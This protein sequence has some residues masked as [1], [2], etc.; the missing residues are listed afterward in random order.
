LMS[1]FEGVTAST[2]AFSVPFVLTYQ[3]RNHRVSFHLLSQQQANEVLRH[4][5]PKSRLKGCGIWAG[6]SFLLMGFHRLAPEPRQRRCPSSPI[7]VPCRHDA[8]EGFRQ[9]AFAGP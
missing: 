4:D 9:P 3:S 8:D 2:F 7:V 5:L 6:L 1:D